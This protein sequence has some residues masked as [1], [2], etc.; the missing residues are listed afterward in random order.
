MLLGVILSLLGGMR[1]LALR[2]YGLC[3]AGAVS[4]AIPCVSCSGCCGFG[5][6]VGIWALVVLLNAD[7]KAAFQ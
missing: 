2:S 7:I 6:I 1:M 4:A 3:I 5:E